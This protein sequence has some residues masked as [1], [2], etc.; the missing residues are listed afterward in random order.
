MTAQANRCIS[1]TNEHDIDLENWIIRVKKLQED[2]NGEDEERDRK[3]EEEILAER[4]ARHERRAQRELSLSPDRL[5]P[6]SC[7]SS[8]HSICSLS[9]LFK[10]KCSTKTDLPNTVCYKDSFE[11]NINKYSKN[12][13]EISE[14][15]YILTDMHTKEDSS[16]SAL[17]TSADIENNQACN[18]EALSFQAKE[19]LYASQLR[20]KDV[21]YASS[22]LKVKEIDKMEPGVLENKQMPLKNLSN[23]ILSSGNLENCKPVSSQN[24]IDVS[25]SP[26]SSPSLISSYSDTLVSNRLL[27]SD[28]PSLSPTKGSF[29][30]SAAM[31][32][33]EY[34]KSVS[35][36]SRNSSILSRKSAKLNSEILIKM[37]GVQ[38][39][40][41]NDEIN[42]LENDAIFSTKDNIILNSDYKLNLKESCN[43]LENTKTNMENMSFS[44]DLN[45]LDPL[46]KKGSDDSLKPASLEFKKLNTSPT[47][48]HEFQN[49]S[50]K[51]KNNFSSQFSTPKSSIIEGSP[52]FSDFSKGKYSSSASFSNSSK[53]DS[54]KAGILDA[55]NNLRPSFR[56]SSPKY[57]PFKDD[58][59]NAKE[60]LKSFSA[61]PREKSD[62]F[63]ER[64]LEARSSLG[65]PGSS[66]CKSSIEDSLPLRFKKS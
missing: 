27:G 11:E 17:G 42:S 26:Y 30:Q 58:I 13:S 5:K 12:F 51:V 10:E 37:S 40:K 35:E 16:S 1:S 8:R 45:V 21:S 53:M 50:S 19:S 2:R 64:L 49:V 29:V 23:T 18:Y 25:S 59:L 47:S 48:F 66:S 4:Q 28:L 60:S 22:I 24:F 33:N 32:N 7:A 39:I 54:F 41:L 55:K 57:D 3:L 36:L 65:K 43:T 6:V 34:R 44:G 15:A 38:K 31:K 52:D 9:N 63:K 20:S 62:I 46:K 61:S 14:Q 56:T